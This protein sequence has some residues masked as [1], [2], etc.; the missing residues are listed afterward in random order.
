[1]FTQERKKIKL[2]KKFNRLEFEKTAEKIQ[3]SYMVVGHDS[4]ALNFGVLF[5]KPILVVKTPEMKLQ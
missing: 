2:F 5:K 1:M 3:N 4:L